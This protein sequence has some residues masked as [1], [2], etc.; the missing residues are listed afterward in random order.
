VVQIERGIAYLCVF[1]QVGK[2]GELVRADGHVAWSARM[3]VY[4]RIVEERAEDGGP[5]C[6][7]R[8]AGHYEDEETGLFATRF[9]V[10]DPASM[11]WLSPDPLGFAVGP[12]RYGFGGSPAHH[13]DVLGLSR[14]CLRLSNPTT[15]HIPLPQSLREVD[16]W[17]AKMR[18]AGARVLLVHP[19]MIP[20]LETLGA[21]HRGMTP[22]LRN[23]AA[24]WQEL[25]G[26]NAPRFWNEVGAWYPANR[27]GTLDFRKLEDFVGVPGA[28]V[29]AITLDTPI[30]LMGGWFDPKKL[31]G[32]VAD[33]MKLLRNAGFKDVTIHPFGV[34]TPAD[35]LI[36]PA[37][38]KP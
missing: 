9:R 4:G 24:I 27:G 8:L 12:D 11:R 33:Q 30:I 15:G 25:P 2:V 18:G 29:S 31:Q 38:L 22:A 37:W 21:L 3:D 13:A 34:L 28:K 23:I 7:F 32:C 14:E 5:R 26:T 20:A 35:D 17:M 19:D 6:P 16:A 10:F 1:D 36:D